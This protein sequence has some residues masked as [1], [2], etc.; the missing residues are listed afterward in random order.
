M[1]ASAS[2]TQMRKVAR[3]CKLGE[4]ALWLKHFI[5]NIRF[6]GHLGAMCVRKRWATRLFGGAIQPTSARLKAHAKRPADRRWNMEKQTQ[7]NQPKQQAGKPSQPNPMS[8]KPAQSTQ[9][10]SGQRAQ[11]GTG[12]N[13]K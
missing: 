5:C 9:Q 12:T 7:E 13:K 6:D 8:G 1:V 2:V 4:F 10:G 11:T 3:V